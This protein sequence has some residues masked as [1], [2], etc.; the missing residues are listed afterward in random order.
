MHF[1]RKFPLNYWCYS[2]LFK[3][4]DILRVFRVVSDACTKDHIRIET[5]LSNGQLVLSWLRLTFNRKLL[6][7]LEV[8]CLCEYP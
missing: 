4:S 5:R 3:T 7:L 8:N 2:T 1:T 6:H